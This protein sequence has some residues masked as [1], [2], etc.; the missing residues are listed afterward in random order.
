M[1]LLASTLLVMN[2]HRDWIAPPFRSGWLI[3]FALMVTLVLFVALA[4]LEI[5]GML[6]VT[7]S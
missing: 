7:T 6:P 5:L 3:N 2:N 4:A 1:P